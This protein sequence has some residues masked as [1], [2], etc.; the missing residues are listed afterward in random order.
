MFADAFPLACPFFAAVAF[1]LVFVVVEVAAARA[2]LPE[3]LVLDL[4]YLGRVELVPLLVD[5]HVLV[6]VPP[7]FFAAAALLL[8][9]HLPASV[10]PAP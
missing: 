5:V 6:L 10:T 7:V 4:V 2:G 9:R 8:R 1:G 3:L